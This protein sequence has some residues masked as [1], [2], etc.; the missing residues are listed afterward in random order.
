VAENIEQDLKRTAE[1]FTGPPGSITKAA[2]AP[3]AR[4]WWIELLLGVFWL[5]VA[6]VVLKFNHASVATVGVLT[7][8]MFLIFAAEEFA[9]AITPRML[10]TQQPSS[11]PQSPAKAQRRARARRECSRQRP[12]RQPASR[13][14]PRSRA[15]PQQ[16]SSPRTSPCRRAIPS[17]RSPTRRRP[18]PSRQQASRAEQGTRLAELLNQPSPASLR[19]SRSR[20]SHSRTY[21]WMRSTRAPVLMSP[22]LSSLCRLSRYAIACSSRDSDSRTGAAELRRCDDALQDHETRSSN[23]RTDA[24]QRPARDRR[25][26]RVRPVACSRRLVGE[27]RDRTRR[28]AAQTEDGRNSGCAGDLVDGA[29]HGPG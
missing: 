17:R 15:S 9:L 27:L 24:A 12:R 2:L 22:G 21:A 16:P 5:I 29:L 18:A 8:I 19:T 20:P 26:R 3:I 4:F 23:R 7:G 14:S 25:A 1:E 11:R 13:A 28:T 10:R 6:A